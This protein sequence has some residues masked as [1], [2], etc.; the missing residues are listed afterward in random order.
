MT[1]T[2]D[3]GLSNNIT[4]QARNLLAWTIVTGFETY[5]LPI[6]VF[7]GSLGNCL[8]VFVVSASTKM[9]RSSSNYYLAAL[10]VSDTG[11]L[12][13]LLLAWFGIVNVPL[14]TRRGIC[15]LFIYLTNV[16][17]F[18]S[19]WFVVAFTV[20]RFVAVRYPLHRQWI[21]TYSRAKYIIGSVTVA[22]LVLCSPVLLFAEVRVHEAV[23]VCSITPG[24]ERLATVLNFVDT[25]LTFVL[26][27]SVIVVLNTLI[28]RGVY[29]V[30]RARM[31]LEA[32]LSTRESPL[33]LQQSRITKMLLIVSSVFFCLNLPS[34]VMRLYAYVHPEN[35]VTDMEV[36][37]QRCCNLLFD[38][39][40]GISFG[41]YCASGQNFRSAAVELLSCYKN[42]VG[43]TADQSRQASTNQ[44]NTFGMDNTRPSESTTANASREQSIGSQ[45]CRHF[46]DSCHLKSSATPLDE[47]HELDNDKYASS[48]A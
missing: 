8:S 38:T 48:W 35:T 16:C 10:A 21:C 28:V 1:M 37:I 11:F 27:F 45:P 20:E 7:V 34:Y 41:L 19:A 42:P 30:D 46:R 3:D 39:N 12:F 13:A 18:L 31:L 2:D 32:R 9:R 6:L 4:V 14:V 5:Y 44:V 29:E 47:K 36:L 25:I 17:S 33:A 40:F 22:G 23:S 15:Q 24:W 26:P 43:T